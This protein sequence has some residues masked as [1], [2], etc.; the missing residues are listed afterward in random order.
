MATT[1]GRTAAQATIDKGTNNKNNTTPKS[2]K[3]DATSK[4]TTNQTFEYYAYN[5]DP[6]EYDNLD[7]QT[8]QTLCKKIGV[9]VQLRQCYRITSEQMQ[10]IA[11]IL[12]KSAPLAEEQINNLQ[13]I[14]NWVDLHKNIWQNTGVTKIKTTTTTIEDNEITTQNQIY[15]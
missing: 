15:N 10:I 9:A 4:S 5:I 6:D 8:L 14:T 13:D 1:R 7:Y 3:N 11:H 2:T 12:P